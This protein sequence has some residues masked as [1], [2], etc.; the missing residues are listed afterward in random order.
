MRKH[1]LLAVAA[2][3]ITT[4]ALA[5]LPSPYVG[6]EGGILFPKSTDLDNLEVDF[7]DPRLPDGKRE[8]VLSLDYRNGYDVNVIAGFDLGMFRLEGELGYKRAD[9]KD[10]SIWIETVIIHGHGG[11]TDKMILDETELKVDGRA[12]V[13]SAMV[14][15]L[16]DWQVGGARIYGGGGLGRARVNLLGDAESAWAYQ[17]IGGFAVPLGSNLEA[18]FKYRFFRTARLQLI[19]SGEFS[20]A[21]VLFKNNTHAGSHSLLASLI[22]NF[23][24]QAKGRGQ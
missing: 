14:N 2:A 5:Q 15:G 4:P 10:E 1:L 3:A 23:S 18:G 20:N 8:D 22:F 13:L 11:P 7:D 16:V 6:V 9:L 12:T 21:R 24:S 17:L 19:E